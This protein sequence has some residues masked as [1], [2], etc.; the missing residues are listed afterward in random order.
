MR[1][2]DGA[3]TLS[4]TDLS[5]FLSCRHRTAL[6]MAEAVGKRH[7]PHWEDPLLDI[8]FKRGFEHEKAYVQS[9][10]ATGLQIVDLADVKERAAALA[11]T[12]DAMAS[13]VDAVVQGALGDG[14][15]YGRPD[16]MRRVATPSRFGAWSYEIVD[17]KLAR[18]TRAGT[19]LQLGLYSEMLAIAQGADPEHFF[20]VTPDIEEPVHR[21]RVHDYAAYFRLIR[22]QMQATVAQDD[23]VVAAANY[24][25]P[26]D[27]CDVCPWFSECN[28]KRHLDDH[29]A[30]SSSQGAYRLWRTSR[31]CH[32]L[33]LSIRNGAP[34]K[35]TS[36]S[37]SR[38]ESNSS[39]AV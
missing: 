11:Q 26:V 6:E 37:A 38:R 14:R 27:H 17:T 3:L 20:V 8:L 7:R 22:T 36:A 21:Y 9:L 33:W 12:L 32:W 35:P 1:N 4:A 13:G 31:S 28:R 25:E 30:A 2:T 10:Q 15:W 19:M 16:A 23:E 5:N 29:S 39:R 24:P 18:E 34:P